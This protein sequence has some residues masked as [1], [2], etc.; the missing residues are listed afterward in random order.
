MTAGLIQSSVNKIKLYRTKLNSPTPE[1]INRYKNYLSLYNK[2]KR[3]M[4]AQY[5]TDILSENKS[6]MKK[7][8]SILNSVINKQKK[9]DRLPSSFIVNNEL[10]SNLTDIANGFNDFFTNVGHTVKSQITPMNTTFHRHLRNRNAHNFFLAPVVPH[11]IT[12]A[13]SKLKPKTSQGFDEISTKLMKLII[14]YIAEPLAHIFNISFLEGKIPKDLKI[15]KIIPIYKSADNKQFN[16]YRPISIL[17][18]FSKILEKI[19]YSRLFSFI[20]HHNILYEHQYG[21]RSKHSTVH[22]ILHF[23]KDIIISND[24][25]AKNRTIGTFLDLAKA[26]DTVSHDILLTKLDHYGVR[27]ICNDWFRSYLTE[28]YQYTVIE[29]TSSRQK[30]IKYGVPQGSILGPLLFL[31]YINDIS[32]STKLNLISFADDT[33]VYYNGIITQNAIN[34]FNIELN[35]LHTWLCENE[36]LLNIKKTKFMVF[37]PSIYHNDTPINLHIKGNQISQ[38]GEHFPEKSIKF[39]GLHMDEQL[40]WK[41]HIQCTSAK[42]SK[43]LFALNTAKNILPH[44]ALRSLYHALIH[45]HIKYGLLLWGNAS[46]ASKII[47]LQKRAVRIVHKKPYR[48]HT[49]PLYKCCKILKLDDLYKIEALTFAFDFKNKLLPAS[50]EFFYNHVYQD[51]LTRQIN[52]I[53]TSIRPRTKFSSSSIIHMAPH[54]WNTSSNEIKSIDQHKPF[55]AY[56]KRSTFNSYSNIIHCQNPFC[57][58]CNN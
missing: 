37:G 4:K 53:T 43:C 33:T 16:N 28:R 50:F 47:K 45:S 5:Y 13:A 8:W 57:Q 39:L 19:V 52:N 9:K 20:N 58:Q 7:T 34:E 55:V 10:S 25:S 30:L 51:R 29:N 21:F 31:L 14:N 1:N 17:P 27:G 32:S 42:I 40:S 11:D 23:I 24:R 12:N 46:S 3:T 26:F 54:L 15:A 2:L 35:K 6:D 22:P 18:A 36:L 38:I 49:E 48:S 41:Y 56:L 44:D